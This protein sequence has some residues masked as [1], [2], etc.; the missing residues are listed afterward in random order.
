MTAACPETADAR[1][2]DAQGLAAIIS[3]MRG[4]PPG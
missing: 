3:A 2:V 1:A 4:G